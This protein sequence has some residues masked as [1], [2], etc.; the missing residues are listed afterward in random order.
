MV[1]VLLAEGAS[2]AA[3]REHNEWTSTHAGC[4]LAGDDPS[5]VR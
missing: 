1:S 4:L 2:K 5:K 3:W